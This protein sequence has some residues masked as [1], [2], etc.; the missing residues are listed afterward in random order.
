MV[1][2]RSIKNKDLILH[3]HLI[4]KDIDVCIVTEMWLGQRNI[5]KMWYEST[6]PNKNQFQLFPSIVKDVEE[7][8]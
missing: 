5:D 7:V 2:A 8:V 3:Q 4:E 6:V 1:N